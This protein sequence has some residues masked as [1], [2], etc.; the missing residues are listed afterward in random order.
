[1]S[2]EIKHDNYKLMYSQVLFE[3]AEAQRTISDNNEFFAFQ[4]M[5]LNDQVMKKNAEIALLR[6]ELKRKSL[7]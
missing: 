6:Q 5:Q 4:M 2:A 1:M 3:L 7:Q